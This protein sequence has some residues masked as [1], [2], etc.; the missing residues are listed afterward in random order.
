MRWKRGQGQD[1][2]EDR[3]R[4]RAERDASERRAKSGGPAKAKKRAEQLAN[5]VLERARRADLATRKRVP[6]KKAPA[7]GGGRRIE[8]EVADR[9]ARGRVSMVVP[10][11]KKVVARGGVA[12]PLPKPK[13]VAK[14]YRTEAKSPARTPRKHGQGGVTR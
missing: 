2:V 1:Q 13:K 7:G 12:K 10:R 4:T 5:A 9:G 14:T 8:G 3:R 11:K 6:G